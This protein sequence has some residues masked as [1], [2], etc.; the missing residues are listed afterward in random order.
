MLDRTVIM[1]RLK[2]L[3]EPEKRRLQ[4]MQ[5]RLVA[6]NQE[7][8]RTNDQGFLYQ[9]DV[10]YR[11]KAT[12][13][14]RLP[15]LAWELCPDM[16]KL[17]RERRLFDQEYAIIKQTIVRLLDGS[18]TTQDQ[19]NAMPECLVSMVP[20]FN[21]YERTRTVEECIGDNDMLLRQYQ[22]ALTLIQVFSVTRMLY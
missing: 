5:D 13:H 10:Y 11:S 3:F 14:S 15:A 9:G 16:E 19:R 6:R 4:D 8:V 18:R 2:G 7:I 12:M 20:E 21:Q 17:V 22:K 1:D